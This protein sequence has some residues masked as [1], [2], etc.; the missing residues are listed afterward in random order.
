MSI[1]LEPHSEMHGG[2]PGHHEPPEKVD[3]RQRLGIWLFIGA[4]VVTLGAL[5]FTY[6]YLRGVNTDNHWMSMLGYKGSLHPYD[7]WAD[8]AD[9]GTLKD[10]T[11]IFVPLIST[12]L[13][14][15]LAAL[16]VV[17]AGILWMGEKGLRA[18]KNAKAF[19]SMAL[20]ATIISL[21][22]IV[23][24]AILLKD[25]PQIFVSVNDSNTM[26]YTT[27]DS[28]MMAILGSTIG[29]L[30]ILAFLGLGL[31]IRSARGVVSGDRWHQ[32]R[33]VR[34]FWVWVA[35]SAVVSTLITT[36]ITSVH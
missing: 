33:L 31:T 28:A 10:P 32:V 30:A 17:S 3:A 16:T 36:T 26:S 19:S 20:L 9:A 27:Y 1:D 23:I 35:I 18:T 34:F 8:A 7:V 2:T 15:L 29:H 11:T 12:G 4:D 6:L 13:Q 14:W 24:A 21:G 22:G 5:L 25:I